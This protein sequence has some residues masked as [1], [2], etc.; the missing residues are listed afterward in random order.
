MTT[1]Y[2]PIDPQDLKDFALLYSSGIPRSK[3]AKI[4]LIQAISF[5]L[6]VDGPIEACIIANCPEKDRPSSDDPR[7][8][9]HLTEAESLEMMRLLLD[10]IADETPI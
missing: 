4:F 10:A 7:W 3:P 9:W 5:A 2:E 8:D 6:I 1:V